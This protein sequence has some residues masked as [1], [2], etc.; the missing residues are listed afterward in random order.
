MFQLRPLRLTLLFLSTFL[1]QLHDPAPIFFRQ[2]SSMY[3]DLA[4][5]QHDLRLRNSQVSTAQLA[6]RFSLKVSN[7]FQLIVFL[8]AEACVQPPQTAKEDS[9]HI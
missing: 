6:E 4:G 7:K 3:L 2:K 5:G 9:L 1:D 8:T